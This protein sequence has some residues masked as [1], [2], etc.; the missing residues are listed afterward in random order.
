MATARV[1][2]HSHSNAPGTRW[3]LHTRRA[4]GASFT[5]VELLIVIA[6]IGLL[7]AILLPTLRHA[8][9]QARQTKCATQLRE[10]GVGFQYYLTEYH[11]TFPAADYGIGYSKIRTPTWYQLIERY[12]LGGHIP[13]ESAPL[14][15]QFYLG[16]CP[17]VAGVHSNNQM[18][19]EWNYSWNG[20]GYGYNRFWLGWNRFGYPML[21]PEQTFWRRLA[22]VV[23]PAEC[24]LVGDSGSRI[25]G[26]HRQ[27]GPVT[28]Y[29]GWWAIAQHGSGFDTRHGAGDQE[30]TVP[31]KA[32]GRTA[33]YRDGEANIGWVDGHVSSRSSPQI[34]DKYRWRHL[35]DATRSGNP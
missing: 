26:Q 21:L 29:L 16:C 4:A 20:F 10:Y 22:T 13:D 25:L 2:S 1:G 14:Q 7:V 24:V 31:S 19:W 9:S 33:Y 11:E 18:D 32:G 23:C 17:E 5:L 28:H 12:W 30:P 8:R 15:D 34:N 35:W 3:R 6:I 27:V